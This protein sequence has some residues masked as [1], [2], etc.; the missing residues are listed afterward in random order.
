MAN[1]TSLTLSGEIMALNIQIINISA[2]R[3]KY[4]L[5]INFL[6]PYSSAETVSRLEDQS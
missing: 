1:K 3:I 2:L 5:I 4:V 6:L